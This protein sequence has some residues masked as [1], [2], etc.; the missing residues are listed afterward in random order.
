MPVCEAAAAFPTSDAPIFSTSTGLAAARACASA[1]RN[2]D[3][4]PQA[5]RQ[6]MITRVAGSRAI[7][8]IT[9]ATSM[10]AS[11]PDAAR[12]R[13]AGFQRDLERPVAPRRHVHDA[14]AV[15][16][17]HAQRAVAD[18]A[19]EPLL[20]RLPLVAGLREAG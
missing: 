19:D 20:E 5:S 10:S 8:A 4:S 15:R 12:R 17:E 2:R 6:Q 9:S 3:A 14:D 18:H 11:F 16:A 13:G 1:A 7:H